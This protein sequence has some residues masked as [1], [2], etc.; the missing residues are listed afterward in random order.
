MSIHEQN[1]IFGV[2][3]ES[4]YLPGSGGIVI[5]IV[6]VVLSS[7]YFL[8]KLNNAVYWNCILYIIQQE[9]RDF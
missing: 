9:T 5:V 6:I 1:L 2:L 7:I 4:P 3:S 8:L